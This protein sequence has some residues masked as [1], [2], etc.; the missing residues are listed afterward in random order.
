MKST[1]DFD[2]NPTLADNYDH[3]PRW[4]IPGYDASHASIAASFTLNQ[5][6]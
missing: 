5:Q 3:G 2:Q 1:F 6:F 4:F